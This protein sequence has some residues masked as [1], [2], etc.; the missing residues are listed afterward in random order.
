MPERFLLTGG[1]GF[2]GS[3]LAEALVGDGAEVVVLDNLSTGHRSNLTEAA[4]L[5]VGD[6]RDGSLLQE[7]ARGCTGIFH[8]AAV[9]SV[10]KCTQQ[11][12]DS[13]SINLS[14]S[15]G[16]FELAAEHNIPVVY[17]SSSAIYGDVDRTP[18]DEDAPKRPISAYGADKYAMELHAAAG[19]RTRDL[20]SFGLRFFNIYG[21]RQD[22]HS[23]Y[24]GVIAVF[25]RN[26]LNG[27]PVLIHGTGD[28]VRDFVFV[29]DAVKACRRAM[30]RLLDQRT[31][32][33]EISNVCTGQA[34]SIRKLADSVAD[35]VQ[36]GL[37]VA[38]GPARAGDIMISVG[39]P[40]RLKD[41]LGL[42]PSTSLREGLQSIMASG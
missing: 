27:A 35:L 6:I 42:M 2:I 23:P 33:A 40:S 34:T 9:A 30:E 32:S 1:C 38:N 12:R 22:P 31:A 4:E 37:T 25:M 24:S 11:W 19:A 3:H 17:A 13:H 14:A 36:P 7:A 29:A 8:L 5:I 10:P 21:P 16:I 18:I 39:D 28:Q 15:V 26:A 41:I 20:R